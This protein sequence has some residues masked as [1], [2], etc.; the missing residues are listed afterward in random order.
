MPACAVMCDWFRSTVESLPMANKN[1]TPT[2]QYQGSG[3]GSDG[4]CMGILLTAASYIF[5]FLTLPLSIW[6][7]VKVIT[8][9]G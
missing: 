2:Y 3:G 7:C 9:L 6:A 8:H 5:V 4:G 1:F